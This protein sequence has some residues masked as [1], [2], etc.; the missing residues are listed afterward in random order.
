MLTD[1]YK[2]KLKGVLISFMETMSLRC[3]KMTQKAMQV[4]YIKIK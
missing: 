4:S 3:D 2:G 1:V